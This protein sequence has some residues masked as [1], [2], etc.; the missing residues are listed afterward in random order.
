M[1]C[2]QLV[3]SSTLYIVLCGDKLD[4]QLEKLAR[5][6]VYAGKLFANADFPDRWVRALT[7]YNSGEDEITRC[8]QMCLNLLE[9]SGYYDDARDN[10]RTMSNLESAAINYIQRYPLGRF[11]PI[12]TDEFIGVRCHS[13][14]LCMIVATILLCV[15]LVVWMVY[16]L[17]LCGLA[18][19][20]LKYMKQDW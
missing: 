10:K 5:I 6:N 17:I 8:M 7:Y 16:V 14:L 20:H 18:T 13:M 12:M 9:T 15:S 3:A 11:I 4:M 2:S 1:M 19:Q